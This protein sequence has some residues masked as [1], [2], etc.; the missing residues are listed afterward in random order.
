LFTQSVL[1]VW[2]RACG[3][4]AAID[5]H[6]RRYHMHCLDMPTAPEGDWY[7][8]PCIQDGIADTA[9]AQAP[10]ATTSAATTIQAHGSPPKTPEEEEEEEED[11]P[12]AF[13]ENDL[14]PR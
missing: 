14:T 2:T 1:Y 11:A 3:C 13:N 6:A 12:D 4:G 9:M 10:P 8:I 5:S 7:C